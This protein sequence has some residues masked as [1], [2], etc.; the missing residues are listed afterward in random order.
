MNALILVAHADDETL[1]AGGLIQKIVK[2]KGTV[3]VVILSDGIVRARGIEQDN[4]ADAIR[5]CR[6]LGA[7]GP[8]FLDFPDQRFDTIAMAD[9]S[10]SVEQLN[11][12]PDLIVT[13]TDTDLNRDHRLTAE[14][15]KI[16]GRPKPRPVAILGCE[17][18]N[19]S[20]WNG[21]VFRA[22]YYVDIS[23]EIDTKVQ[24]FSEY[25]NE[26]QT[27]PHP[28]SAGTIRLL[29]QYHGMQSGLPMAEAFEVIRG[30]PG[31]LPE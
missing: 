19:A 4:R 26:C 12:Q 13:H 5:A 9:L 27:Y 23:D 31:Q 2:R 20:F 16:V 29:A 8:H 7:C 3:N 15:A 30:Y 14:V 6:H 1:G 25:R 18:P 22:N 24:A 28:F 11:L 17:I 10:K 21:I